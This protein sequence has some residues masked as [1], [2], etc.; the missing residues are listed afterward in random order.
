MEDTTSRALILVVAVVLVLCTIFA[1]ID[2][3]MI[4]KRLDTLEEKVYNVE[5]E[6]EEKSKAFSMPPQRIYT[7]EEE[8][9]DYEYIVRVLTTEGG[10]DYEVCLAVA[11]CLY[12]TCEKY[13]WEYTP[14]QIIEMY[15]YAYPSN[16]ISEEALT[17]YKEI[18]LDGVVCTE[19]E[20]A[21]IF[22][23]HEYCHSAYHES[24]IF[25]TEINGVRFFK[26]CD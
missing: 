13:D 4:R 19:V 23:A 9:A 8:N 25:I 17:A 10:Y 20:D 1:E 2:D 22:Y 6:K 18:F 5:E 14:A 24:Q 21:T 15:Q 3:S 12:N 16:F 26:E 11:Q 7:D